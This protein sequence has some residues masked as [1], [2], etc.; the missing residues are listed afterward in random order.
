MGYR[1]DY[2]SARKGRGAEKP[3]LRLAALT[4]LCLLI[5]LLLVN[6]FWPAGAQALR[7]F[8]IPGDTAVTVAALED[9]AAELRAGEALPDALES[10]CRRVI[11]EAALDP[12]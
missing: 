11:A 12:G 8:L 4:A 6:G 1:V 3:P 10:F 7:D 5:F 2:P 9:L